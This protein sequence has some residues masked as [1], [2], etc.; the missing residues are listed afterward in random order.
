MKAAEVE[1]APPADCEAPINV[2]IRPQQ[3]GT[4]LDKALSDLLPAY[5]RSMLQH[6]VRAGRVRVEGRLPKPKDAVRGGE[7]VDLYPPVP[8]PARD[9]PQPIDIDIVYADPQV[10]IVDKPAGLVVHPGAGNFDRTLVNALLHHEP[11]LGALPRAGIVH[12]LDKGTSG[13]LMVARTEAS[14]RYLTDCLAR[15]AVRRQYLAV[16]AAP[17][18][19]GGSI[20]APIGRH[21]GDRRRMS[22]A[23]RGRP[24]RSHYRV[25][26]RYRA[27]TLL[28]ID[29]ETGRTHQIRVHLAHAGFPIVGDPVYG[30]RFRTPAGASAAAID[31]LRSFR[32]QALH[33]ARLEFQHPADRRPMEIES[34]LPQDMADL[35]AAL[36]EDARGAE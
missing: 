2:A 33:A 23:A 16:V 19:A 12:R 25:V 3:A 34:P 11:G 27:H 5:S 35:I 24:A 4:R 20:D 28:R 6:W 1:W 32:R 7:R 14:R 8:P 15:R 17:V 30:G 36:E 10:L 31:A 26:S 18:I 13:L 9:L 21:R 29:I 22:V